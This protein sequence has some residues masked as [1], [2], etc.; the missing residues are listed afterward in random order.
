M[1]NRLTGQGH[2]ISFQGPENLFRAKYPKSLPP[3]SHPPNHIIPTFP[4]KSSD[5]FKLFSIFFKKIQTISKLFQFFSKKF[6]LFQTKNPRPAPFCG[7]LTWLQE[8]LTVF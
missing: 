5:Y 6:K 8:P 7:A 2:K 3:K 1:I 4:P